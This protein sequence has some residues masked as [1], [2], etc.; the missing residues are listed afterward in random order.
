MKNEKLVAKAM[1]IIIDEKRID[2]KIRLPKLD[3][4]GFKFI[5]LTNNQNRKLARIRTEILFSTSLTRYQLRWVPVFDEVF[6]E[7]GKQKK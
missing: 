7:D 1:I 2:V 4:S 3:K 6:D 5:T